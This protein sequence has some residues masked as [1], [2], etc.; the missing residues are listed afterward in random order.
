MNI[1]NS[2]RSNTTGNSNNSGKTV[3]INGRRMQYQGGGLRG[4]DLIRQ[5]GAG[6]GRRTVIRNGIEAKTV[7]AN[8]FYP[9]SALQDK[10]GRP[11]SVYS[12]PDRSKGDIRY[13]APRTQLS[14]AVITDQ[15]QHLA[16]NFFKHGVEFDEENADWLLIPNYRLPK[17]WNHAIT[18]L[19]VVF[20]TDYPEIPPVGFYLKADLG[21]SPNGHF[22]VEAYHDAYK[23]PLEQGWKWYCSFVKPGAW[24]PAPIRQVGDWRNGDNLWTYFTLIGEVLG[25]QGE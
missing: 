3:I 2:N 11:V 14:K 1:P 6:D 4:S 25:N 5:S 19:L 18:P 20:P 13:G 22:F 16:A 10:H 21:S 8:D 23:K 15:V 7:A 12:M 24:R 9:D 17:L